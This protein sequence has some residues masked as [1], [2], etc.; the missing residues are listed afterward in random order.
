MMTT[1]AKIAIG[2]TALLVL[3]VGVVSTAF[4][5]FMWALAL[6][7]YMGQQRAIEVS[8]V[9]FFI[10]AALTVLIST[11]LSGFAVYWLAGKKAWN[12]A[13]AAVLSAIVFMIVTGVGHFLC[14][15]VSVLV[16]DQLRTT[17]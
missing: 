3:A 14:I 4:S 5:W 7:G 12:A 6:N 1:G 8:L 10:L 9:V 11:G 13:G 2:V 16:A 17:R 15:L